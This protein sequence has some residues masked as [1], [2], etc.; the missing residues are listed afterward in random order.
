MSLTRLG[1]AAAVLSLAWAAGLMLPAC[2]DQSPAANTTTTQP[3]MAAPRAKTFASGLTLPWGMSFLPDAS[4]LVTE[5]VGSLRL[6]S[7]DGMTVSA[8]IAGVPV[9]DTYLNSQGGLLDVA[10]DPDFANNRW[11]Y[12]SY[13]EAGTGAELGKNGTAVARAQLS[14]DAKS[15]SNVTV[16]FRQQPK[17]ASQLHF[18]SRLVF[19]QDGTLWVTLGER[20]SLP[21][22][23]QNSVNHIGKVVRI[24]SDGTVPADNPYRSVAGAASEIWS[25]GHRN[26]QGAAMHPLT[27]E[28]WTCE[29]G[30]QGG[31]EINRDLPGKNYGWPVISYGQY[32]STTTQVGEGTAKPGMEQPV[33][34]WEFID[35]SSPAAGAAKSS[36]APS[37]LMFYTGDKF[38]EWQGNLFM[39]ALAGKSLWRITL[40]GN[41]YVSRERL[42]NDLGERIRAVKQGPDGWIY[43]LTDNAQGR[44]IRIER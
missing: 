24:N 18:G 9:T 1:K 2:Q 17:A 29:H 40:N 44:I 39:G 28:L 10:L 4:I 6:V 38:P 15:L 19:A 36:T 25:I 22:E 32:Y 26:M 35:G 42:F 8:P 34:Y 33:T 27:G 23:A 12:L 13:S 14:S 7:A 30:P 16:I 31:D 11:V 3:V 20:G 41:T 21:D 5:R 37:G 43:L